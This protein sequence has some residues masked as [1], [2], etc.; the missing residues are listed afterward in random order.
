MLC[1]T[2]INADSMARPWTE[3]ILTGWS[4]PLLPLGG[5]VLAA[6][7]YLRGWRVARITRGRELPGWRAVSFIGGVLALWIPLA[8][9]IASLGDYIL[10]P[11]TIRHFIFI[12]L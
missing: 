12:C 2:L 4:M 5:I 11:P 6:V 1:L 10:G 9:P 8:S 7:V 3:T